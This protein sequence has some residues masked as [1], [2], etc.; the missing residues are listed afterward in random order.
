M[1]SPKITSQV[2]MIVDGKEVELRP[3]AIKLT[4]QAIDDM[5]KLFAPIIYGKK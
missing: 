5:A 1:Q 3:G 4:E 2:V